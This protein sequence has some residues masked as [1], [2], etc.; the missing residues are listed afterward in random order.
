MSTEAT[1]EISNSTTQTKGK[2]D[3]SKVIEITTTTVEVIS[4]VPVDNEGEDDD[5]EI[6]DER[7]PKRKP[8]KGFVDVK[9]NDAG[10]EKEEKAARKAEE[11]AAKKAAKDAKKAAKAAKDKKSSG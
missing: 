2:G 9:A 7:T 6:L 11:E 3:D 8:V 1:V 10:R 5:I 4:K